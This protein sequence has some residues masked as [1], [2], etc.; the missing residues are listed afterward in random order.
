MNFKKISAATA[1]VFYGSPSYA[2]FWGGD[3]FYS[4]R[5]VALTDPGSKGAGTYQVIEQHLGLRAEARINDRS[6]FYLGLDLNPKDR[7][8][9]ILGGGSTADTVETST[10]PAN[11]EFGTAYARIATDYCVLEAGRRPRN[12]GLGLLLSSASKPFQSNESVYDGVT[13]D[14]NLQKSQTLGFSLGYD[15]ITEG[16]SATSELTRGDDIDQVFFTIEY[17]DRLAGSSSSLT[18][19]IGIYV[20]NLTTSDSPLIGKTDIKYLDFYGQFTG[21]KT[22]GL[23]T[24]AVFRNGKSADAAWATYGAAPDSSAKVDTVALAGRLEMIL[25]AS[26][27]VSEVDSIAHASSHVLFLEYMRAPG[28]KDAYYRG[29]K[30]LNPSGPEDSYS[31]ITAENR[32]GNAQAMAFNRNFKPLQIL[33]NGRDAGRNDLRGVYESSKMVNTNLTTLG[34]KF[35]SNQNGSFEAKFAKA[36]LAEIAP[37]AVRNYWN[38]INTTNQAAEKNARDIR[39]IDVVSSLPVGLSSDNLGTELDVSYTI[40]GSK[41]FK[42]TLTAA[43]FSPGDALRTSLTSPLK[44]Q[45]LLQLQLD[46]TF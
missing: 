33:F 19:K 42:T 40:P 9:G 13:C 5:G 2:I 32:D 41:D 24:E 22:F 21:F 18:K 27:I 29:N 28:D 35:S 8:S 17:D 45:T 44:T 12:W 10:K 20:A 11:I 36:S 43:Y 34:Y 37:D 16:N 30:Q 6:S 4:L 38:T 39:G 15:K 1:F 14:V 46:M 3:G 26:G 25:S 7:R 23:I 31:G